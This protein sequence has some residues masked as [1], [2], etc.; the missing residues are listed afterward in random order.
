MKPITD[1]IQVS[2]QVQTQVVC[3]W[4]CIIYNVCTTSNFAHYAIFKHHELSICSIMLIFTS[5]I[6]S[7]SAQPRLAHWNNALLDTRYTSSTPPTIL[8]ARLRQ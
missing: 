8:Y 2:K 6:S 4:P 1:Y 7:Y 3:A 5:C